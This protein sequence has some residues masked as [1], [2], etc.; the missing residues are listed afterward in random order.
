MQSYK[1][2]TLV[3][4]IFLLCTLIGNSDCQKINIRERNLLKNEDLEHLVYL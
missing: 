1:H 4:G 3:F 2:F